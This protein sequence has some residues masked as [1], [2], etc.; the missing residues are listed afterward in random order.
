MDIKTILPKKKSSKE[1]YW[2][3]ILEQGWVQAGI[4][5]IVDGTANVLAVGPSTPWETDEELINAADTALSA[6]VQKIEEDVGEPEK[7]VIGVS[8]SWVHDGKI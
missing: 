7:T 3:L 1:Y 5:K 8:G 4:W 6:V 2:S